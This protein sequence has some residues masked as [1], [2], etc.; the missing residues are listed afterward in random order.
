[1]NFYYLDPDGNE[2][3]PAALNVLLKAIDKDEL[4]P[5]SKVRNTLM[6]DFRLALKFPSLKQRLLKQ[7]K[8]WEENPEY[9]N[10]PN[11][12]QYFREMHDA[13]EGTEVNTA[14]I[15]ALIP[16]DTPLGR[17]FFAAVTDFVILGGAGLLFFMILFTIARAGTVTEY[18][19][20]SQSQTEPVQEQI[21]EESI[22]ENGSWNDT[23]TEEKH[24]LLSPIQ[25]EEG[26]LVRYQP[27]GIKQIISGPR[28]ALIM[29]I[30][31]MIFLL[32]ML[33]YYGISLGYYAQTPGMW[34]WGIFLIRNDLSE[35]DFI[36]AFRWTLWMIGL[37]IFMPFS[38]LFSGKG[39][40]DWICET[41]VINVE[42]RPQ[43]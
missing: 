35:A 38:M 16:N 24:Q 31:I 4:T 17:R 29:N 13:L 14:F 12:Q 26:N 19:K 2:V 42:A 9:Q 36:T 25:Y 20:D 43:D 23:V 32:A 33:L 5:Y 34:F 15:R 18:L 1:M 11:W 10:D 30:G 6:P 28:L 40:Q 8:R 21:A 37:G 39:I 3:G 27:G 7:L 41:R 22:I